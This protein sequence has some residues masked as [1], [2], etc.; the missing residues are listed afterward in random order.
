M[1]RSVF[2][3]ISPLRDSRQFRLLFF[4]QV[5]SR[6]GQQVTAVAAP[7]QVFAIT[8]STLA[9]GFLGLVQFP[10][11]LF[12]AF[13]GGALS[14]AFDRRRILLVGHVLLAATSAALAANAMVDNPSVPIVYALTTLNAFFSA[15]DSPARSATVP[16]LVATG[17]LPAAFALQVLMFTTAGA[18]GPAV[19]GI[20]IAQSSLAAAYWLDAATFAVS[21]V[22]LL[23]MAPLPPQEGG[24]R[25]GF[26]SVV[27]GIRFMRTRPE[28]QGV[29]IIDLTAMIFG[30]PRALFPEMGLSTFGGDAST[31]GFLFAAPSI[32][33]VAA[34]FLSGWVGR[35]R[36]AGVATTVSVMAWGLGITAFGFTR[37]LVAALVFLA[38]AGG[39]DSISAVFRNTILQLTTPDRLRGRVSA[40]QIAVVAGGPRLGDAEAG[41]VAAGFGPQAAAWSGGI[42]SAVGALVVAQV[43]PGFRRWVAPPEA[44]AGDPG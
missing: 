10:A 14:D 39:G 35:I 25:P 29:F 5:A 33:A 1:L 36:R 38:I 42:I 21:I 40:V 2:V 41:L 27:E 28:L 23:L 4:G 8:G 20:V 19:A 16:R 18:A 11:L 3:D 31:V 32:G 34:A 43:L 22:A 15:L 13:L 6:L 30:M 7:I 9:V 44:A 12:G 24:T 37:H 17:Q 26:R